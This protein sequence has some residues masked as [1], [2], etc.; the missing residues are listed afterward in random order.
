MSDVG[1]GSDDAGEERKV[2]MRGGEMMR[3]G[4]KDEETEWRGY[5]KIGAVPF[6]NRTDWI[7]IL[8][9]VELIYFAAVS[10]ATVSAAT[11]SAAAAE[12]TVK[13]STV[14]TV[15]IESVATESVALFS[16]EEQDTRATL[17]TTARARTTFFM[18]VKF[19][20]IKQFLLLS[21]TMRSYC[22]FSK[23]PYT[24]G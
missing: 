9:R 2:M 24:E 13:E 14:S 20:I 22:L 5:K 3:M 12:S 7:F 15:S 6:G 19:K 16:L 11:V 8:S 21:K 10:V 23:L 1:E 4:S 17:N 18:S